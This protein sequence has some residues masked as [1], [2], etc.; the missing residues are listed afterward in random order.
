MIFH[1]T[2]FVEWNKA[3]AIGEYRAPSLES[4]GF[5]H[6]S[7]YGQILSVANLLYKSVNLPILLVIDDSKL[8]PN[9]LKWEGVDELEFPHLYRPVKIDEVIKTIPLLK[10]KS[11]EFVVSE[12]LNGI[13]GS[14]ILE[15][16]RLILRDFQI[17]DFEGLHAYASDEEVV[18]N[19]P[20]GPNTASDSRMFLTRKF[21]EQSSHPRKTFD[22]AVTLKDSG[23]MIGGGGIFVKSFESQTAFIGYVLNKTFHGKGYATEIAK[24]LVD[25]GFSKLNLYRIEATCDLENPASFKVMEKVGMQKEGVLRGNA[26]YKGRRRSTVVCSIIRS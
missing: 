5:I 16:S 2:S 20:W 13:S 24:S 11:G 12:D 4:E 22:F 25:F 17:T 10:N 14:V 23:E 21:K 1:L 15:T 3:Q 18:K 8:D 26:V 6:F 9:D 19:V 7:S